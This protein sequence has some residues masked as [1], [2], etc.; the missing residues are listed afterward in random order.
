MNL[1]D[2]YDE[3]AVSQPVK[4]FAFCFNAAAAK[5]T[6]RDGGL[7]VLRNASSLYKAM[8]GTPAKDIELQTQNDEA[9]VRLTFIRAGA[10]MSEGDGGWNNFGADTMEH[11]EKLFDDACSTTRQGGPILKRKI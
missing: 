1:F 4:V 7:Y 11:A 2:N 8:T 6:N 10:M 9:C 3:A 5:I